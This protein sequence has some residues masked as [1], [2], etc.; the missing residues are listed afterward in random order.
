[1]SLTLLANVANAQ[2]EAFI[3]GFETPWT[4]DRYRSTPTVGLL[5]GGKEKKLNAGKYVSVQFDGKVRTDFAEAKMG[6]DYVFNRSGD[7]S[8]M[9][10]HWREL[11]WT[12]SLLRHE[13][14]FQGAGAYDGGGHS[15]MLWD[16]LK[17]S[18]LDFALGPITEM[19]GK[20]WRVPTA[21]MDDETAEGPLPIKSIPCFINEWKQA[22]GTAGNGVPPGFQNQQGIL[23]GAFIDPTSPTSDATSASFISQASCHQ[24]PYSQGATGVV[25]SGDTSVAF[26]HILEQLSEAVRVTKY[27]ALP[28]MAMAPGGA[29]EPRMRY[30]MCSDL[31]YKFMERV[32]RAHGGDLFRIVRPGLGIVPTFS[33][34]PLM[35]VPALTGKALY[36]DYSAGAGSEADATP[37]VESDTAGN[38]GARF[39]LIDEDALN[40][41]VHASRNW[42]VVPWQPYG[43]P[44]P[45]KL[46]RYGS[47]HGNLMMTRFRTS[48]IVYP[49]ADISGFAA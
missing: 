14:D 41:F 26:G 38:A 21:E 44:S 8:T 39:Y 29:M 35:P 28:M 1:M 13:I 23:P 45:D 7:M 5:L 30:I 12:T 48:A 43:M 20:L 46:V 37:L 47:C 32:V 36:P 3:N 19:E 4:A 49:S 24:I 11:R 42:E 25:G 18:N 33:D 9:T 34:F 2:D 27:D 16:I 17:K 31:G 6:S 40:F 15:R 22:H 10:A